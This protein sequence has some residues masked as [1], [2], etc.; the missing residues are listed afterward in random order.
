MASADPVTVLGYHPPPARRQARQP[1]VPPSGFE[2]R[3][4]GNR[5]V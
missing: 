3:H 1:G 4:E 5:T 2:Q